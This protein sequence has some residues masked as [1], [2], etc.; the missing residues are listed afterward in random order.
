MIL[1]CA[2]VTVL[3]AWRRGVTLPSSSLWWWLSSVAAFGLGVA[4]FDTVVD[5]GPL[6]TGYQPGEVTFALRGSG[7]TS[8]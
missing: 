8:T 7:R 2:V 6:T 1:A 3:V 4:V 5:G